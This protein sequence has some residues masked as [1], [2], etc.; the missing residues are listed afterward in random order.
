MKKTKGH[1]FYSCGRYYEME[2]PQMPEIKIVKHLLNEIHTNALKSKKMEEQITVIEP[3]QITWKQLKDFIQT[4]SEEELK[5]PAW[6]LIDDNSQATKLLE[7]LRIEQDIYCNIDEHEDC[8]TLAE[9][10]EL[11]G[12]DFNIANYKLSTPKGTPFLWAETY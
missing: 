1:G 12:D 9:L 4:L 5:T 7:P 10:K 3:E 11:A 2:E 8:G 6:I